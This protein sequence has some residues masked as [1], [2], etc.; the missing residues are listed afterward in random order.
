M[1]AKFDKYLAK[2]VEKQSGKSSGSGSVA[3]GNI[4]GKPST[5]TPSDHVHEISD[6][7]G[8]QTALDGKGTVKTVN[9][10]APDGSGNVTIETGG[11]TV[12]LGS[13]TGAVNITATSNATIRAGS[14]GNYSLTLGSSG[15]GLTV[16]AM[17]NSPTV[18]LSAYGSTGTVNLNG[19]KINIGGSSGSTSLTLKSSSVSVLSPTGAGT[20]T[21]NV[22]S[23]GGVN[24]TGSQIVFN[25]HSPNTAGGLP[26]IGDDGF[27]PSSI[28]P[29]TSSDTS[30]AV[31]RYPATVDKE[32]GV[33][34]VTDGTPVEDVRIG[35]EIVTPNGVYKKTTDS[36]EIEGNQSTGD[37]VVSGITTPSTANGTYTY[38][39]ENLWKNES[40]GY[41]FDLLDNLYWRCTSN[42][43]TSTPSAGV[44][45]SK[46]MS[47]GIVMPWEIPAADWI[48][49]GSGT[50][51]V[52]SLAGQQTVTNTIDLFGYASLPSAA[53]SSVAFYDA[54]TGKWSAIPLADLKAKL[55]A[56][57]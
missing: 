23:S 9:G 47:S 16:G 36:I 50:P 20:L 56:L 49:N 53:E 55:E 13:Y 31:R 17:P 44:F 5:F 33:V 26:L 4:T 40:A 19:A 15:H 41:W 57:T 1:S 22:G 45:Y 32:T 21:I 28:I 34:S 10:V 43:G 38:Q 42:T 12:D 51:V 48:V 35:D 39:S 6:V 14:S 11:G 8:L 24:I 52:E 27:L 7:N 2:L 37:L 54:N 46:P 3:W 18:D 30:G 25:G 29:Q